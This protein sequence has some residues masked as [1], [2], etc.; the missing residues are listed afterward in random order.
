MKLSKEINVGAVY[1][2]V[3]GRAISRC[4]RVEMW[5]KGG[6]TAA[7]AA[8]LHAGKAARHEKLAV[9]DVC[10]SSGEEEVPGSRRPLEAARVG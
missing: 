2:A 3:T 1:R 10:P 5:S 4:L 8:R 9:V 7:A 6:A